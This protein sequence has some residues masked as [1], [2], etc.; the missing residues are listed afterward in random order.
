MKN[1]T[2]PIILF[3]ICVS[4]LF[5]G[6][7][8]T[9]GNFE[10]G[11]VSSW[12]ISG[13]IANFNVETSTIIGNYSGALGSTSSTAGLRKVYSSD[14]P[15]TAGDRY[16]L[17]GYVFN[18]TGAAISYLGFGI[19]PG[20]GAV[21]SFKNFNSTYTNTSASSWQFVSRSTTI[22]EGVTEVGITNGIY[23]ASKIQS[24]S[25]GYFDN[26][27]FGQPNSP[28][29]LAQYAGISPIISGEWTNSQII[30]TSFTQS[31]SVRG[32]NHTEAISF[33]LQVTSS[34]ADEPDWS[35]LFVDCVSD[36]ISEG[37]TGYQWTNLTNKA[38]YWWR[39]W[40]EDYYYS[41]NGA[42]STLLYYG[43]VAKFGFDNLLPSQISD[44]TASNGSDEGEIILAWTSPGNDGVFGII[45][46]GEFSIKYSTNPIRN[47]SD[48][49]NISSVYEIRETTSTSAQ[50]P[51][52]ITV[53]GLNP[54]T[55]YYFA[56]KYRD[57]ILGNWAGWS[58]DAAVNENSFAAAW[59]LQPAAPTNLV[60]SIENGNITLSWD[61]VYVSDFD[62]YR[63]YCDSQTFNFSNQFSSIT[64]TSNSITIFGLQ[65]GVTFYFR[66][67]SV[68]KGNQENG[69][70]SIAKESDFSNIVSTVIIILPPMLTSA[71]CSNESV[72]L[73]WIH[74]PDYG[75]NNFSV[76][77]VYRST[78][79]N[80]PYFLIG[81][82][83]TGVSYVDLPQEQQ[84]Y[85]YVLKT[86]D[87]TGRE[88]VYSNE[89]DVNTDITP[90]GIM[91]QP[92]TEINKIGRYVIFT[93]TITDSVS[94]KLYYKKNGGLWIE[95][96]SKSVFNDIF[97][98]ELGHIDDSFLDS[99]SYYME[100][101]DSIG[102]CGYFIVNGLAVTESNP[103]II[104][105]NVKTD[106]D[107]ITS[108]DVVVISTGNIVSIPNSYAKYEAKVIIPQGATDIDL[109]IVIEQKGYIGQ[110]GRPG[111]E[112]PALAQQ[113]GQNNSIDVS[114]S[115][116][117]IVC[118]SFKPEFTKFKKPV[119]LSFYY[120]DENDDGFVDGTNGILET[121]L[122][123]YFWDY[124]E[125][126]YIG[127]NVDT[128]KNMVMVYVDHFTDFAL[129]PK[130][131]LPFKPRAKERFLTPATL[132]GKN[133]FVQFECESTIEKIE[134]YDVTGKKIRTI[135]NGSDNWNGT[136]EDGNIVESGVYIYM[137][138]AFNGE[139]NTGAVV[140]AK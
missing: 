29:Q 46:N 77:N 89:L 60:S 66:I 78:V 62:Y 10:D 111:F 35:N 115:S 26:V 8:L 6:N 22:A 40:S 118:F 104:K 38:T 97:V 88:S 25:T 27:Y 105:V 103:A 52:S 13:K 109:P 58:K 74:S 59:D 102:N 70:Y 121:N 14:L 122:G 101:K 11:N 81:S 44:L 114:I 48:F 24:P 107:V 65:I 4:D 39:V 138:K 64:T 49:S 113:N 112:L 56:M 34:S 84:V 106:E 55:T 7:L 69:L 139:N 128:E 36:F 67:T 123:V 33:H 86:L 120:P 20:G 125:W 124:L 68:D 37:T 2:V 90:P 45:Y 116:V 98:F 82:T 131:V 126:R 127:G 100:A 129:F 133:D 18:S 12:T 71:I 119:L 140:V 3:L 108:T 72:V 17:C 28:T 136:D 51:Y 54:G 42:T 91:H 57:G 95:I 96:S 1:R 137:V 31:G 30:V 9:N 53:T 43:G 23:I 132:D 134:I 79:Q 110:I 99:F 85:W 63:I 75:K 41:V 5:A 47:D 15:V 50:Q 117:A 16:N 73:S 19:Q 61:D 135:N 93:A 130:G 80:G 32:S 87:I 94:A 76:Y 21:S 92:I 83:P